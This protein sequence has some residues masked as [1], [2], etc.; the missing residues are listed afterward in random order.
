[1]PIEP[2]AEAERLIAG[3]EGGPRIE[4]GGSQAYYRPA[5]DLVRLAEPSRFLS[6][7]FYY[8]TAFHELAH[9]TGH[10]SRLDRGLDTNLAPFGT[11]DYSREE[12]IAE[13]GAAFLSAVAGISPP[14]I[15]QSAAYI[16]GWR[17]KLTADP[18][19]IV[20]AAGAGQRAA[21]W[22]LGQRGQ[23]AAAEA[24]PVGPRAHVP[25]AGPVLGHDGRR[26][27]ADHTPPSGRA[28][29]KSRSARSRQ[30]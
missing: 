9:S 30:G 15:E 1:M 16:A 21:H 13:M 4:H 18:K 5:D 28:R 3:Y 2:I 11:A 8:A 22:V 19:L 6:R 26:D 12:L 7:E 17:K 27:A 24:G 20:S 23:Q 25:L 14:T 10:S 29:V